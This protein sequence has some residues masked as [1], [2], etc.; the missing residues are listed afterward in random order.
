MKTRGVV[1]DVGRAMLKLHAHDS[2]QAR[3][4]AHEP[5]LVRPRAKPATQTDL[6]LDRALARRRDG[7]A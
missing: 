4:S 5:G 7:R 3:V 6:F 2:R 1:V